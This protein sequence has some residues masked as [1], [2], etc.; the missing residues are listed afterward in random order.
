MS[1]VVEDTYAEAFRSL[2]SRVLV[3][4]RDERWL[5]N[6]CRAATG[7]ASSTIMCDCEAG[8]DRLL[9][10]D[11]TPDG[12]IGAVLQFHV[13]RFR[14][15]RR[16]ALERAL[17]ARVSQNIL[18]CPT[19]ACFAPEEAEENYFRLGRK[20]AYFGDG[21]ERLE[22][23][24]DDPDRM[25]AFVG[26]LFGVASLFTF[27][28]RLIAGRLMVRFGL[29]AGLMIEPVLLAAATLALVAAGCGVVSDDAGDPGQATDS[30]VSEPVVD[31]DVDPDAAPNDDA[32]TPAPVDAPSFDDDHHV[33]SVVAPWE[34]ACSIDDV[35]VDAHHVVFNIP[36]D[37]PDGGL[38]LRDVPGDGDIVRVLPEGEIVRSLEMSKRGKQIAGRSARRNHQ[39][40]RDERV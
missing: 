38:N 10:P 8:V 40:G 28:A 20:L 33:A 25:A 35:P 23:R 39:P 14:K 21:Y 16:E 29:V 24:F 15:D 19:A 1:A 31:G 13:P 4:A 34:G 26:V 3:T 37:D 6:A 18:T 7:H 22:T 32:G 11:E 5:D 27:G 17:L 2:Y 36:A 30:L 9:K 12:R